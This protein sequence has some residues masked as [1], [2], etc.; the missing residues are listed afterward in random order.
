MPELVTL[1]DAH[2]KPARGFWKHFLTLTGLAISFCLISLI[3]VYFAL[4]YQINWQARTLQRTGSIYVNIRNNVPV[5]IYIN[6]VLEPAS[7]PLTVSH[8]FPGQYALL[9][10]ATGYQPF[11][12][13]LNVEENKVSAIHNLIMVRTVPV[14]IA[15]N[16][17]WL[18]IAAV[19][20]DTQVEVRNEDEL[21]VNNQFITRTSQNIIQ[22]RFYQ[23]NRHVIYQED[24][25]LWMLDLENLTS[26]LLVSD[27]GQ[28]QLSFAF[29]NGGQVLVYQ[30][31][32]ATAKAITLY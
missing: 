19:S 9:I 1:Y 25:K 5:S 13:L 20:P 30:Q 4:G 24:G 21:W 18:P 8:L 2:L 14:P 28:T 22:T 29:E 10:S 7:R 6:G 11:T 26:K 3:A 16:P 23:D 27:I 32:G 17:D 12:E 15:V 31:N